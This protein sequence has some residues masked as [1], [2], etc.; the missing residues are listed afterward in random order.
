MRKGTLVMWHLSLALMN[1]FNKTEAAI[2]PML[3]SQINEAFT[4]M[5]T[6]YIVWVFYT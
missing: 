2:F 3:F 6:I 5:I 4:R 1:R